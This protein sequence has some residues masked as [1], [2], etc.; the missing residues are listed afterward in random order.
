MDGKGLTARRARPNEVRARKP[1]ISSGMTL[2]KLADKNV[3]RLY[4]NIREQVAADR[5]SR[6]RY[7]FMG[8][9]VKKYAERLRNEIDRRRLDYR[10]IDWS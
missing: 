7:R 6:S 5:R 2:E 4:E 10:P 8:E 9:T 1:T 3:L